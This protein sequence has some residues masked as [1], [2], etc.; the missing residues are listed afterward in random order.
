LIVC[1]VLHQEGNTLE[2]AFIFPPG[3]PCLS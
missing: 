2:D 1:T 3:V